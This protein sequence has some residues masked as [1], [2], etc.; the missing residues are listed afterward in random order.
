MKGGK[1]AS[2]TGGALSSGCCRLLRTYW[3]IKA[4]E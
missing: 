2:A 1:R 3:L 4:V